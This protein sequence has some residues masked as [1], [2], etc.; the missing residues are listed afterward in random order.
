[1]KYR[2]IIADA[3]ELTQ[4]NKKLIWWFAFLPALLT[5][6]VSLVYLAYQV[7]SFWTSPLFNARASSSGTIFHTLLVNGQNLIQNQPGLVV[8][9]VVSVAVIALAWIMLPVFTQGALIQ[10]IARKRAGHDISIM[11]GFSFG[12][13]RFLQLF[14][15]HLFIKTF[16]VVSIITEASF[17]LRGLGPE[18]FAVFGWIFLLI[19]FIG[20]MLTL[21]F[22]YAEYYI[23][24]D[25]K[26][27]FKSIILSSGL[28]VRHWH[29]TIFMFILMAIIMLRIILN[30]LV[31]LL[32]PFLV[33]GPIFFFASITLAIIGVVVGSI[34]GLIALYFASYFVGIFHVFATAV[35]TFTFLELTSKKKAEEED[36]REQIDSKDKTEDEHS[37]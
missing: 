7:A 37:S 31:A 34:V 6:L 4:T 15:Y 9:L 10:L 17:V 21:L 5:T 2:A 12:F 18:A 33:I 16:S 19:L 23:V 32:I 13:T 1:M 11:E 28:V 26:G 29:H 14:E 8:V 36:L 20:L 27:V 24:I 30:I 3:W 22:T 35:W 25:R